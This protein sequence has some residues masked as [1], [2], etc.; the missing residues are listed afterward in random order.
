[1]GWDA[2][3][4]MLRELTFGSAPDYLSEAYAET[5]RDA[6]LAFE[7]PE[8]WPDVRVPGVW[9]LK[10]LEDCWRVRDTREPDAWTWVDAPDIGPEQIGAA[11]VWAARWLQE[12]WRTPVVKW[13]PHPE[14]EG[15]WLA[16]TAAWE[17]EPEPAPAAPGR[18]GH[19]PDCTDAA[20]DGIC[21]CPF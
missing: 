17:P 12:S 2:Y 11:K 10:P 14:H 19:T 4:E 21:R 7:E 8:P 15:V 20:C 1:M 16:H 13:E 5:A 6:A 18:E 9:E 3:Q